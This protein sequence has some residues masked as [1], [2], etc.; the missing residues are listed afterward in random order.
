[1]KLSAY[2]MRFVTQ[3]GVDRVFL[4]AGGGFMQLNDLLLFRYFW[5]NPRGV[6]HGMQTWR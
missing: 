5:S 6:T 4:L 1:M 2:G 3:H